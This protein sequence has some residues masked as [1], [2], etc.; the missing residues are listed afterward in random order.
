MKTV[1]NL[2]AAVRVCLA[3]AL[4]LAAIPLVACETVKGA[5]RDIQNAGDAGERAIDGRK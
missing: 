4:T 5:G 3:L 2:R 1:F